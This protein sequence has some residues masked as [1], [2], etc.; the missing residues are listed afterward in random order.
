MRP[1]CWKKFLSARFCRAWSPR[2]RSLTTSATRQRVGAGRPQHLQLPPGRQP[3][4]DGIRGRTASR[5]TE[6]ADEFLG[7]HRQC[8]R[9][10]DL[11][12]AYL[13]PHVAVDEF[14]ASAARVGDFAFD[15]REHLRSGTSSDMAVTMIVAGMR[16]SLVPL[17]AGVV[18]NA[19]LNLADRGRPG[20]RLLA[21]VLRLPRPVELDL[22]RAHCEACPTNRP[23]YSTSGGSR[24]RA[25]RSRRGRFAGESN[26]RCRS[27]RETLHRCINAASI[28][29]SKITNVA[30]SGTAD[31]P[32]P[33]PA[34]WPKPAFQTS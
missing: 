7:L 13:A 15:A 8:D 3:P 34:D 28:A 30:G 9:W 12:L 23:R 5:G 10:T 4:G 31:E 6:N 32:A 1:A 25:R 33:A 18:P 24:R 27:V 17:S 26:Y 22:A 20:R 21:G 14:A 29:D 19:D 11:L 16:S 2:S